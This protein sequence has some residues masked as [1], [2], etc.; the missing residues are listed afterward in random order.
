MCQITKGISIIIPAYNAEKTID[1]CIRSII[2]Q[3]YTDWE[4]VAVNDGS[5]DGT[6]EKLKKWEEADPRITVINQKNSGS[7]P[8]RNAGMRRASGKYI[9]FVDPDD[10][11]ESNM[12]QT[13]WDNAEHYNVDL[14]VSDSIED[15]YHNGELLRSE[16]NPVEKVY[17]R[18]KAETR[19]AYLDFFVKGLIRGPVCKLY[20]RKIIE[21]NRIEFPELRRSQD[22]VF[23][24]RYFDS[25]ESIY[26]FDSC[27]Y[28]YVKEENQ[29]KKKI[30]RDYYKAI[31]KIYLD[32]EALHNDWGIPLKG[33]AFNSYCIYLFDAFLFQLQVNDCSD[34][35]VSIISDEGIRRLTRVTK[36]RSLKRKAIR[37]FILYRMNRSINF[38]MGRYRRRMESKNLGKGM[39]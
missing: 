20:N 25:I 3:I 8:A 18:D 22:I 19:A 17:C 28:H 1:K 15:I 39:I 24:Y 9:M 14:T 6:E 33:E 12:L 16:H 37:L 27:L 38:F 7:G 30:P 5:I 4:I 31:S 21:D 2:A 29:Q 32:V 34:E 36:P 10:W 11:I 23:N 13:Y 26:V 35:M